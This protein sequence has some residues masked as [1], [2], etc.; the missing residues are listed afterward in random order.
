MKR[1][2]GYGGPSLNSDY[3]LFEQT[4]GVNNAKRVV[5]SVTSDNRIV[6]NM[7]NSENK[8]SQIVVSSDYIRF[9]SI[10]GAQH[11]WRPES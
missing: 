10:D 8:N 5:F 6:I 2:A 11:F 3:I 4:F 1:A 9:D 7:A